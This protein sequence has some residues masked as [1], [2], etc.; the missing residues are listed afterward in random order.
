MSKRQV[1]IPLLPY[2][3]DFVL[4]TTTPV[5]GMVA[6]KGSGKALEVNELVFTPYGS[7]RIGDVVVG[8]TVIGGD[9]KPTTIIIS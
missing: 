7:K 3:K 5:I 1:S 8:D 4:D 2:Q 9:G 6:G